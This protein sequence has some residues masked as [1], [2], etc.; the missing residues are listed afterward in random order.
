[1]SLFLRAAVRESRIPS[2]CAHLFGKLG[3]DIAGWKEDPAED[4]VCDSGLDCSWEFQGVGRGA[5]GRGR[6]L[7]STRPVNTLDALPP[8]PRFD[9]IR[10]AVFALL[11]LS[12]A[13]CQAGRA[14]SASSR[15]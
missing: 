12:D 11:K 5:L 8:G 14:S 1:M 6:V 10:E 7:P 3:E 2:R 13:V 4:A 15:Q 9:H